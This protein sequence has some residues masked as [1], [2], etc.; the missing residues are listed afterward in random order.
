VLDRTNDP[1]SNSA[2]ISP[3]AYRFNI[4]FITFIEWLSA[5]HGTRSG[6]GAA[7]CVWGVGA[8]RVRKGLRLRLK[9]PDVAHISQLDMTTAAAIPIPRPTPSITP[10][11]IP[12][13]APRLRPPVPPCLPLCALWIS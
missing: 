13:F 3:I 6:S 9:R 10:T 5:T 12:A 4:A 2:P 1:P 11:A 8:Q 7:S